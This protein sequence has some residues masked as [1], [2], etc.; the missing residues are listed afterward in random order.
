MMMKNK[1]L[2][3]R[4]LVLYQHEGDYTMQRERFSLAISRTERERLTDYAARNDCPTLA[5]AL[6]HALPRVFCEEVKEGRPRKRPERNEDR[7]TA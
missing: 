6:R 3:N 5:A 4:K 1:N 7:L 2:Q